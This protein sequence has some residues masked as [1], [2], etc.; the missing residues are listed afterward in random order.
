MQ[1]K[2]HIQQTEPFQENINNSS[3]NVKIEPKRYFRFLQ[4]VTDHLLKQETVSQVVRFIFDV[5]FKL[6]I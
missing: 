1:A 6:R 5:S 4:V 3:H 2:L